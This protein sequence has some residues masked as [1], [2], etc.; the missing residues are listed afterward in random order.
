MEPSG[1]IFAALDCDADVI[2][3]WNRWYDLEHTPPNILLDGVMLSH[4]Y[5]APP[6][7]HAARRCAEDSPFAGGQATFLTV[8]TLTGDPATAFAGMSGL[9]EQLVAQG[10]MAFP[11]DKKVVREGDVFAAVVATPSAPT[12]LVPGDVPF[13]GHTGLVVI[14]R[15]GD[16]QA[17]RKRAA[18]LAELEPVHGVWSLESRNR[19]GLELDLVFVEGDAAA[20]AELLRQD[21]P[22]PA[23][24]DV[25]VDAPFDLIIPLRYPWADDIRASDLPQTISG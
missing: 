18:S 10:R 13:V 3:A 23:G 8:Y 14:Q 4:R 17:G 25:L 11:D 24:V 5:V 15:R 21:A 20:A 12:R 7:L 1:I 22:V 9:R 16:A 2:E 6:P 19:P